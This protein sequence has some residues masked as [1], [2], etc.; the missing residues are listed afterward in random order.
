MDQRVTKGGSMC[1]QGWNNVTEGGAAHAREL[2][3]YLLSSY[4]VVIRSPSSYKVASIM[5]C[6]GH[7]NVT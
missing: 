1:D 7:L 4:K 2:V 3:T 5:G 6:N